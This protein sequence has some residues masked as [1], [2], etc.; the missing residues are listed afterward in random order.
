MSFNIREATTVDLPPIIEAYQWLFGPPGGLPPNWDEARARDA[1]VEAIESEASTYFVAIS[2]ADASLAGIC[3]A[4]LDLNSVRY[5]R[6]CWI[7]DLAVEPGTRSKGLGRALIS[8]VKSWA[9]ERGATHLELDTGEARVDAQRFYE[10]LDPD[11][12]TIGY[13]WYLDSPGA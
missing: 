11:Q 1:I 4:Y 9:R 3:S 13:G 8:E 10:Q 2:S 6:R 5:G 12:T 7:E